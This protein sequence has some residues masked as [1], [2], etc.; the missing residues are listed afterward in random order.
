[1]GRLSPSIPARLPDIVAPLNEDP[2]FARFTAWE[3]KVAPGWHVNWV[4]V[5]TR[6]SVQSDLGGL[7]VPAYV[8][9]EKPTLS[10]DYLEWITVLESVLASDGTF[11]MAELGAGW[12]RW[13]VNAV[14]ALRLIDDGRPYRLLA[15]EA[16]PTHF[17]WMRRHFIDNGI[18]PRR[19][20]LVRAA[21]AD[22]DGWVRF[23]RG[24][25][26]DWY[27]QSIERDDPAA[28]L[29]GPGSRLIR[30]TRNSLANRLAL[31]RETRKVRRSRAVSLPSLLA[32]L[33]IV[34]LVDADIQGVEADVFEAAADELARKVRRVHIGTHGRDNER[35][36]R[37]LF[38]RLGWECRFDYAG[39]VENDTPWGT[40]AFEDGIQSW[41]NP[42][43][44][45]RG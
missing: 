43:L 21:V 41:I 16:E 22:K 35:R 37:A 5:R 27:G 9:S 40:L 39:G 14:A 31:G 24:A 17:A 13:V 42:A 26:A 36:L 25:P 32:P 23:E 19:H 18:D 30:W 11:T 4:G 28:K 34:D 2:T 45:L 12:G 6:T 38:E 10:E 1:L 33:D 8:V 29:A 3:G 7:A 44:R 15:V 20:A